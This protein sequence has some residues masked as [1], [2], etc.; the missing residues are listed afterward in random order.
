MS[1]ICPTRS[2]DSPPPRSSLK[3]PPGPGGRGGADEGAADL[4][5]VSYHLQAALQVIRDKP[6]QSIAR[7]EF[8]TWIYNLI[9]AAL[10]L[11]VEDSRDNRRVITKGTPE[12]GPSAL[13]GDLD[14]IR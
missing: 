7:E 1:I 6:V 11:V 8:Y 14:L 10:T 2:D 3:A 9:S 13:A 4:D 12:P 5:A